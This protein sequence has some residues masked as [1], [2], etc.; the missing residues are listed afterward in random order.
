VDHREALNFVIEIFGLKASEIAGK[1]GISEA[2]LSR[3]RSGKV[4]ILASNLIKLANALEPQQRAVFYGLLQG[5]DRTEK[6]G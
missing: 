1:S 2:Q 4:D 5:Q 3:F 6:D